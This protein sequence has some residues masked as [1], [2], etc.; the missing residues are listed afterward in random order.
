M[1]IE[2]IQC[3]SRL[4]A[5]THKFPMQI[6]FQTMEFMQGTIFHQILSDTASGQRVRQRNAMNEIEQALLEEGMEKSNCEDGWRYLQKYQGVFIQ[7]V[8]QSVLITLRSH[9]D[10]YISH[11]GSF[12]KVSYPHIF[13]KELSNKKQKDLNQL[14]FKEITKQIDI[15]GKILGEDIEIDVHTREQLSEISLVRNLGLHNRWEV[16][17]FYLNKTNTSGWVLREIRTF[18]ISELEGWHSALVKLIQNTWKP[19]AIKFNGA[20]EY[21]I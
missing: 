8:Q 1:K 21:V 6:A 19:A 4:D 11:L 13:G 10:W 17:S 12:I 18:E 9:W 2:L 7:N 5:K 20:P 16:D 14:G 15:L 3:E